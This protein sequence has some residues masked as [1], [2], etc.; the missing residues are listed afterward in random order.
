MFLSGIIFFLPKEFLLFLFMYTCRQQSLS[1]FS[2]WKCIYF[3]FAR[4]GHFLYY[5]ARE[6]NSRFSAIFFRTLKASSHCLLAPTA[7]VEMPTIS[8]F[9]PPFSL[10]TSK[11]FL[12]VFGF[13]QFCYDVSGGFASCLCCMGSTV[14]CVPMTWVW[15]SV[16]E[17]SQPYLSNYS[18]CPL[19]SHHSSQDFNYAVKFSPCSTCLRGYFLCF[20]SLCSSMDIF[21]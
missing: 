13:E 8:N 5:A 14:L 1:A 4:E 10:P 7:S 15:S 19:L 21:Y 16:W 6:S 20:P 11:I 12:F 3:A 17:N 18:F 9:V 2:W